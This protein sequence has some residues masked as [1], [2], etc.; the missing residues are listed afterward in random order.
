M[1]LLL[2]LTFTYIQLNDTLCVIDLAWNGVA[3]E[4]ATIL[5]Q[6]LM[7]NSTLLEIDLTCNR[8]TLEG[9][10]TLCDGL[11]YN[12]TLQILKV[13]IVCKIFQHIKQIVTFKFCCLY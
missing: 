13:H 2:K 12:A 7:S 4:G 11:T 3:D 5:A 8:I 6:V 1:W 10:F 9:A